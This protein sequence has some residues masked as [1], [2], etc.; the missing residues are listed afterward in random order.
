M[1]VSTV[2]EFSRVT[3]EQ[4]DRM[5]VELGTMRARPEGILIHVCGPTK[6]G[7]RIA[8]VWESRESFDQFADER[9][10][11]A[12]ASVGGPPPSQREVYETYNAGAV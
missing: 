8:N 1:A 2:L 5:G 4:Y 10:I 6:H 12:M 7:W 9:L 3:Q 11:S